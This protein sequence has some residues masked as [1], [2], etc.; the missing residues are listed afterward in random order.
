[1][2]K[3]NIDFDG[4]GFYLLD[5][6]DDIMSIEDSIDIGDMGIGMA[7]LYHGVAPVNLTKDADCDDVN[8]GRWFLSL[9]SN[10]SDEITK[11]HTSGSVTNKLNIKNNV[12]SEIFPIGL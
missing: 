6:N 3:K 1:M 4:V 9:Y 12:K 5:Q 11:R 7:T 2:S 10:V 8:D